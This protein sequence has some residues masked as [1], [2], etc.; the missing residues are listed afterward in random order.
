ML[1][2]SF[3]KKGLALPLSIYTTGSLIGATIA[4]LASGL[5]IHLSAQPGGLVVPG[6]GAIG[7]WRAVFLATG[8][9]GPFLALLAF[10]VPEPPRPR[11]ESPQAAP[12]A[13]ALSRF[14]AQNWRLLAPMFLGF[15]AMN[16]MLS[17][18]IVWT[19]TYLKRSFGLPAL[20]VGWT[21]AGLLMLAAFPGQLFSGWFVNRMIK[22]G[23]SDAY[24]RYYVFA[25][26]VA[27]PFGVVALLSNQVGLFFAGM[28]PLYFVCLAF[29][30]VAST[31]V[32][33]MTPPSLRGRVSALFIM[34]TTLIGLGVGPTLV[35]TISK[36]IDPSGAALGRGVAIV[37]G[38]ALVVALVSLG[39]SR[40]RFRGAVAAAA[41]GGFAARDEDA[42][43]DS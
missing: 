22:R 16:M 40:A 35:A 23:S 14:L 20:S 34:I 32:Q 43:G 12:L 36:A 24:L 31:A 4:M 39:T 17:S 42:G 19:P 37:L 30:G 26:P 7:G 5:V 11:A 9:P 3:P 8:L 6:L 13:P 25:L 2:D 33:V 1:A 29:M 38:G 21:I 28:I 10:V 15:G 18:V 27:V 41:S